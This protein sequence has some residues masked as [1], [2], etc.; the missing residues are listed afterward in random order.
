MCLGTRDTLPIA[1]ATRG[2][3]HVPP[4]GATGGYGLTYVLYIYRI[5]TNRPPLIVVHDEYW[6]NTLERRGISPSLWLMALYCK[7]EPGYK[8]YDRTSLTNASPGIPLR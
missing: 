3:M 7:K 8:A 2:N 6:I 4:E 5:H 1:W